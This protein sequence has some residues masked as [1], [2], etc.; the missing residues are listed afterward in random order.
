MRIR[1]W[2]TLAVIGFAISTG[3][4]ATATSGML[5]DGLFHSGGATASRDKGDAKPLP[6]DGGLSPSRPAPTGGPDR[7]DK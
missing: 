5:P 2:L 3:A 6:A 4:V 7:G 1:R